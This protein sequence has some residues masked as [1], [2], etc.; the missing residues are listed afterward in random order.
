MAAA[1]VFMF[2]MI[3][4]FICL[5]FV[6]CVYLLFGIGI[7]VPSMSPEHH[8]EMCNHTSANKNRPK[9]II[10]LTRNIYYEAKQ[11][12]KLRRMYR[13]QPELYRQ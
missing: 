1:T 13:L 10:T 6:R 3:V 11:S 9:N 2:G 4:F 5:R 8:P 12:T 7:A